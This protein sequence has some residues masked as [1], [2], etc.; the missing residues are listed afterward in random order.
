M[1]ELSDDSLKP[2]D[3][4]TW[5]V[6]IDY[7]FDV[8]GK[9]PNDDLARL[10]DFS[11]TGA[12]CRTLVWLPAFLSRDSLKDLGTLVI[13]DHILTG[14]RFAGVSAHLS[15]V[16]RAQARSLLEN[17]QSQLRQKLKITLEGAYGIAP[18]APGSID[19]SHE[20][21]EHFQSLDGWQPQPPVGATLGEAF[22]HFVGQALE[23]QFPAHPSFRGAGQGVRASKGLGGRARRPPRRPRAELLWTG[24]LRCDRCAGLPIRL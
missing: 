3:E 2:R 12:Q 22:V 4:D 11:A 20:L 19:P 21:S 13:L 15:P 9:T 16:D 17:Q 10:Q 24:Q 18:A 5:R 23:Q 14:E 8:D 6:A 1:R 7:P